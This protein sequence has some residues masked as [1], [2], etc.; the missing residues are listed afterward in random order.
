MQHNNLSIKNLR[1]FSHVTKSI[2]LLC[3]MVILWVLPIT[4]QF[5]AY[6]DYKTFAWLNKS[7]LYSKTWQM[8]WGYLNHPNETW[9]NIVFMIA[10]NIL[11]I[12]TIPK[13]QRPRAIALFLYCWFTFQIA[14]FITH[15]IFSDW[16]QIHRN[17]PSVMF[18]PWVILSE[19]LNVPNIKVYS[20]SSFPAGHVLV[21]IY[22]FKFLTMYSKPW[23]NRLGIFT[24][25]MLTLPRMISGAHW[26][27]DVIFTIVYAM[28][29]FYIATETQLF[30][31]IINWLSDKI[32]ILCKGC[33]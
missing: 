8:L 22:W 26:L 9:L 28:M 11:G 21:L 31:K 29:W 5:I 25:L 32:R 15:G 16:L 24:V 20:S 19:S 4:H 18:R 7:L 13:T 27:S 17:S 14:L 3:T 2:I 33:I 12:C 10:V 6:I 30:K 23:V 1:D